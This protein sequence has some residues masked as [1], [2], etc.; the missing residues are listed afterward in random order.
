M[1]SLPRFVLCLIALCPAALGAQPR[2]KNAPP[3]PLPAFE[4]RW[5]TPYLMSGQVAAARKA[6]MARKPAEAV[7]VL[8]RHLARKDAS[9]G[10]QARYLMAHALLRSKKHRRAARLFAA[11]GRQYPLLADYHLYY[12][13]RARHRLKEYAAAARLAARVGSGSALATD[14][15]LLQAD[16]LRAQRRWKEAAALWQAYVDAGKGRRRLG[17][18]HFRLGQAREKEAAAKIDATKKAALQ[19]RAH[20]HYKK[21]LVISPMSRHQAAARR[22]LT[23]LSARGAGKAELTPWEAYGRASVLFRRMRNRRS[24]RA[25]AALLGRRGVGPK[26][27]CKAAYR[28]AK[29]VFK[30]RQRARAEPMFRS[31]E[32]L[33]RKAGLKDMVVKSIYNGARGLS[34]GGKFRQA[35][36]QYRRLEKEFKKHSY[37]D[38]ACLRMAE[39][40]MEMGQKKAA[41]RT[42]TAIPRKYPAGDMKREALWRLARQAYIARRYKRATRHLDRIIRK[43]G[44]ATIYYAHGRALYWKARIMDR[45]RPA[46][47]RKLYARCIEEYPLSYYALQ[48]FNRLR[49]KHPARFAALVKEHLDPTGVKPGTWSFKARALFGDPNFLRGVELARLGFGDAAA[50]ELAR[51]GI[52]VKKGGRPVDLWLAAV[53]YDSAGIWRHSHQVPRSKDMRYRWKYP[54][55][56]NFRRWIVSYPRAFWP[57]VQANAGSAGVPWQL[58]MA[59][60]REESGFSPT[61]ES[62]ANAM[63]LMQLILPTAKS[64]GRRFKIKVT[65]RR[66]ND[67]AVNI[68]L[69][70]A[71]LGSLNR[72][73]KGVLPLIIAGYNAGGGAPAKWLRRFGQIPLDEYLERVPYDQTRR[74]TKR[75]LASLFIYSTLYQ[76]GAARIPKISQKLPRVKFGRKKK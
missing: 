31:A 57:L 52:R 74:Y 35:V 40:Y 13:A 16:A 22:R 6:L 76:K 11:L 59:V 69:G 75:V 44:R 63:G 60:M 8:R 38:D 2:P 18:I 43:L 56:D 72:M 54:H 46:A 51:A 12:E 47:A 65:R 23:V 41:R 66:L 67:P 34:R 61:V 71:Y 7:K 32:R 36:A 39:V 62:Y 15:S 3:S 17:E 70:A 55:G 9:Y 68:K 20:T 10:A 64:A 24:E 42:L 27:R 30:Q 21:V 73:F 14:A 33:C 58:V 4:Q 26:L 45:R 25:Y 28:M 49:E 5:L 29:S 53:L 50:R 1:A 37:A 48:S 19:A